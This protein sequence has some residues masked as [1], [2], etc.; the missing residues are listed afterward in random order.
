MRTTDS[1]RGRIRSGDICRQPEDGLRKAFE[2][3]T[4]RQMNDRHLDPF[5]LH[6]SSAVRVRNNIT[7][8]LCSRN[9]CTALRKG[10]RTAGCTA[11]DNRHDC[12]QPKY[13]DR[14]AL[15]QL[16]VVLDYLS[17]V[18]CHN[19]VIGYVMRD[20]GTGSYDD[21]VSDGYARTDNKSA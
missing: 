6:R 9:S 20:D 19:N 3:L 14:Y 8:L 15:F 11:A 12:G 2:L 5:Y 10:L 17:G 18:S 1:S 7:D 13:Y 4:C 16:L 21:A